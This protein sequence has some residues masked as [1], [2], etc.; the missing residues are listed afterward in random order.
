MR[1]TKPHSGPLKDKKFQM[2]IPSANLRGAL[3]GLLGFGLF[4]V[5]DATIKHLG[6]TYSPVQIVAF[7]GLFTLPLIALM[8]LRQPVSLRP[9]HPWLMA[10]RVVALIG[11][12]L[13]VTYAFTAMPLA[14]AYA[15]F[16]TL[17]LMLSLIAWPLLGDRMDG[18]GAFAVILGLA[19][20]ILALNPSL[21][22]F[23][24]AHLAAILG[25]LLAAVH[26]L[27]VRKTGGVEAMVPM[28]LYPILGQTVSAFLI[29][30]GR[31]VPMPVA[32]LATIAMM[33]LFG[34]AGTLSMIAAYRIAPPIVVAPMQYS[35]IAWAAILGAVFFAEPM[36]TTMAI[37]MAIIAAA[38]LLVVWRKDD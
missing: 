34:F 31:Y 25:T 26:Y 28:M 30:P 27:I 37:G 19:G 16:F 24:L 3:L 14:E 32:D 1:R 10:I 36:S 13:L 38:G 29:L 22:E 21:V 23:T 5:A 35:Q 11:N 4:S 20:V 15:I 2:S 6:G 12:G 7:A 9:A 33:T 8:W 17:P 18:M